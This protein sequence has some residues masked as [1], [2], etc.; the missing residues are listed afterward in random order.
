MYKRGKALFKALARIAG[1]GG[2]R[3]L[4]FQGRRKIIHSGI[5]V[6]RRREAVNESMSKYIHCLWR[7]IWRKSKHSDQAAQIF[8]FQEPAQIQLMLELIHSLRAACVRSQ[9]LSHHQVLAAETPTH[10]P[11]T[12]TPKKSSLWREL[13][14][15]H[16]LCVMRVVRALARDWGNTELVTACSLLIIKKFTTFFSAFLLGAS[17]NMKLPRI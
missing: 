2:N 5:P 12:Q 14:P 13:T 15:L 16:G 1:I 9:P 17:Y 7:H 3:K 8:S 6:L 10:C 11:C 4:H